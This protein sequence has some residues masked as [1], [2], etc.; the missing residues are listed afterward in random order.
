MRKQIPVESLQ[1]GMYVIELDRPWLETPFV[2]QGFP[3]HTE[4]QIKVLKKYCKTVYIETEKEYVLDSDTGIKRMKSAGPQAGNVAQTEFMG[5][6]VYTNRL[7]VEE[8]MVNAE[9]ILGECVEAVNESFSRLHAT[10]ELDSVTA[11]EAVTGMTNSIERNADAMMLLYQIK[12]RGAYEFHRALDTSILMMTFARFLQLT[13]E[14]L[15]LAGLAGMFLDIGKVKLPDEL[16]GKKDFLNPAEYALVKRH[17]AYSLDYINATPGIPEG[18]SDIVAQHHE[19]QDGSG[20]PH[21]LRGGEITMLAAMAGLVDTFSALTSAR[22]Y[23]EQLSPSNALS[24][25]YKQ[26]GRFFPE[27][28]VEQ[29]I[30]CIGIYPVGSV[31]EMNTGEV[32]IVIAQNLVRRLQP[33][34]MIILDRDRKPMRTQLILDLVK[35]PRA[36]PEEAYKIRRTLPKDA[37]PINPEDFFI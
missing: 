36:T 24:Y 25:L 20:Y 13:K 7:T 26:K 4:V 6:T 27:A 9:K 10:G 29:F 19:R 15:E 30:Q 17:V 18:L 1:K 5:T 37:L 12:K 32:A 22:P 21:G 28:L 31:V 23:A 2:Y 8:E 11:K 14:Q 35:S 3:I 34:V 16:L 33:R